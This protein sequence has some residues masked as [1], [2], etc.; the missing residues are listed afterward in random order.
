MDYVTW[1]EAEHVPSLGLQHFD[2][3]KPRHET[4]SSGVDKIRKQALALPFVPNS[5]LMDPSECEVRR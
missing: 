2:P 3:R 5:I 1:V 4:G